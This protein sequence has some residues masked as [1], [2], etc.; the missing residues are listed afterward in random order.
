MPGSSY[1]NELLVPNTLP[2]AAVIGWSR[3]MP[4]QNARSPDPVTT[5]QR[6]SS[7]VR[8]ERHTSRSSACI[9]ALNA[10]NTFGRFSVT[11]ITPPW[12]STSIVSYLLTAG[13]LA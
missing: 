8:S 11:T 10:F 3:S 1:M 7:S 6:I 4:T 9:A 5:A 13:L 12:R 2:S